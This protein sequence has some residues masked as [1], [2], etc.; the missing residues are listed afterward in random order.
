MTTS[1]GREAS[2]PISPLFLDRWSPRSLTGE[3][4]SETDLLTILEAARW[5]PSAYN[6][7]PWRFLYARREGAA[8]AQYL[9]LLNE[10]NQG[11]AKRASAIVVLLSRKTF[12]P[13]GASEE[14]PSY[15]HSFDAGAAWANL[16]LQAAQLAGMRMRWWASTSRARSMS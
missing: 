6:S 3:T 11:W 7:Q 13:A 14:K 9:G 12:V 4:I 15:S 5:A 2:Y 16:A 8:W 10:F 1:N